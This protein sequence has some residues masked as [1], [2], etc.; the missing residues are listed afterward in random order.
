MQELRR[1]Q[2]EVGE[3]A[4]Q[5]EVALLDAAG[6]EAHH[7]LVQRAVVEVGHRRELGAQL[8]QPPGDGRA[9]QDV[10]AEAAGRPTTRSPSPD[11][12]GGPDPRRRHQQPRSG[13]RG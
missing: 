4:R 7:L 12:G 11:S 10:R 5:G 9:T 3:P 6:R 13:P 2:S 8:P 1:A